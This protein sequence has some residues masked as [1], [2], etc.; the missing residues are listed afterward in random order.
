MWRLAWGTTTKL[1]H[2]ISPPHITTNWVKIVLRTENQLPGLCTS[3]LNDL[4]GLICAL[5]NLVIFI[6]GILEF[7]EVYL[8]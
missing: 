3:L 5:I 2:P 7:S 6:E 1:H 8:I 4:A